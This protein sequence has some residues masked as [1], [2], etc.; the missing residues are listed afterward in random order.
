MSGAECIAGLGLVFGK[1]I[2]GLTPDDAGGPGGGQPIADPQ[3]AN[4]RLRRIVAQIDP[5]IG[6]V[7]RPL[8]ATGQ[9]V[10]Q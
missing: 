7:N 2:A 3:V 5:S 4:V 10:R 9:P 8:D 1:A 6:D